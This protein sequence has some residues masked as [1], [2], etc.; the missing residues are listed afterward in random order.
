MIAYLL[1]KIVCVFHF[2]L[3]KLREQ[4]IVASRSEWREMLKR[5]YEW[6]M[7]SFN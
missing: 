2:P 7:Y 3:P 1:M 5:E 6:Q 4:F